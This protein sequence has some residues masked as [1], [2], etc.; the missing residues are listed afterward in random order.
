M[1]ELRRV[2]TDHHQAVAETLFQR[3]QF[4]DDVQAV[5]AAERP[6]V[7]QDHPAAQPGDGQRPV[8]VATSRR[9]TARERARGLSSR[10]R[11][12]PDRSAS[13]RRSSFAAAP[14]GAGVLTE[15][16]L[17]VDR[18]PVQKSPTSRR[19][20]RWAR[21]LLLIPFVALL[22]PTLY[23]HAEPRLAGIPFFIWY[24][25]AWVILGVTVT[26]VVYAFDRGE[27]DS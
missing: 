18:P 7:E 25:F 24:Q 15:L 6:E 14:V 17:F 9:R 16:R 20:G 4:L 12:C 10:T 1:G 19:R 23:A 13:N 11:P 2:H 8:G 5:D 26:A 3:T 21:L 22:F 27:D